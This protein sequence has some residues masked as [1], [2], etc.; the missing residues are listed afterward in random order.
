MPRSIPCTSHRPNARSMMQEDACNTPACYCGS[1]AS[2]SRPPAHLHTIPSTLLS[3]RSIATTSAPTTTDALRRA[4]VSSTSTVRWPETRRAMRCVQTCPMAQLVRPTL[5]RIPRS[6]PAA[7]PSAMSPHDAIRL[8]RTPSPVSS[9]RASAGASC[10]VDGCTCARAR[11]RAWRRPARGYGASVGVVKAR[12]DRAIGVGTNASMLGS[13]RIGGI[14]HTSTFREDERSTSNGARLENMQDTHGIH[15][16]DESTCS[17][18]RKQV[19]PGFYCKCTWIIASWDESSTFGPSQPTTDCLGHWA[20]K[21]H[22][23]PASDAPSV[24]NECSCLAVA[25]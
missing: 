13:M 16:A 8:R 3:R 23:A 24:R 15:G 17:P 12:E 10:N 4:L 9:Y 14:S 22:R 25:V 11:P 18:G 7:P 20:S 5:T 2:T 1:K 21:E 6:C 19:A